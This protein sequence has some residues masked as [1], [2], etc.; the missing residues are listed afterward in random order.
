MAGFVALSTNNDVYLGSFKNAEADG[1]EN[2][3]WV[4]LNHTAKT[5]SLAD[6]TSG[7]GDILFVA[8]EITT[9]PE[10]GIDDIDFKVKKDEYLRLSAP[11]SGMIYVTTKF[12][13]SLNEGDVVAVG[14]GGNVEAVGARTPKHKFTV[15]KKSNEYGVDTLRLLVI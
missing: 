8:N 15:H 11:Q 6:A 3:Q 1:V 4:T 7:D 10:Y 5:A 13:G 2:G 14:V 9:I 12:N